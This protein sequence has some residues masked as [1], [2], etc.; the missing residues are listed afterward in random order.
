LIAVKDFLLPA[1][2][3]QTTVLSRTSVNDPTA[4]TG[5]R[6]NSARHQDFNTDADTQDSLVTLIQ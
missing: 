5:F 2:G 6:S 1:E 3:P 4:K